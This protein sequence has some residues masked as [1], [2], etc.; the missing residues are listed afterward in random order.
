MLWQRLVFCVGFLSGWRDQHV[1][2]AQMDY[3]KWAFCERLGFSDWLRALH[4]AL[5]SCLLLHFAAADLEESRGSAEAARRVY[6]DLVAGLV[7]KEE[8][9]PDEAA[10]PQVRACAAL[11]CEYCSEFSHWHVLPPTS[12]GFPC[13]EG[14]ARSSTA[15]PMPS[16]Q[17]LQSQGK[18]LALGWLPLCRRSLYQLCLQKSEEFA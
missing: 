2:T 18:V 12:P 16:Q 4:Q 9:A 5:F 8:S 15:L 11:M 17:C 3:T 10:N 14:I 1:R 7:P 13:S 6:E